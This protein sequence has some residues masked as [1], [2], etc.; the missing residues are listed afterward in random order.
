MPAAVFAQ[1]SCN[2]K[3]IESDQITIE[4]KGGD[5]KIYKLTCKVAGFVSKLFDLFSDLL[6]SI[7]TRK[8][9]MHLYNSMTL[10]VGK[11]MT[12]Q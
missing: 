5:P 7:K 6:S 10:T 2:G 11:C 3:S 12:E 1:I 4:D 8:S 9:R